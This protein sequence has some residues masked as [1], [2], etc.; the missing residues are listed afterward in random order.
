MN[1]TKKQIF[2]KSC[3]KKI[4]LSPYRN[5]IENNPI[6]CDKCISQIKVKLEIKKI[7]N[8][9]ILFISE[10]DGLLKSMLMNY[11]EYGDIELAPCFLS[12]F[13][14]V[15]KTF[16]LGYTFIPCP[17]SKARI[18]KR[19]FDHLSTILKSSNLKYENLLIKNSIEEQKNSVGLSRFLDKGI[20]LVENKERDIDKFILFDDVFTTGST[21]EQSLVQLKKL[22]PKRIKGMIIMDNYNPQKIKL[23]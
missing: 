17:S 15:I 1:T 21:F 8:I 5:F 23:H 13:L 18:E 3:F 2:C 12:L 9:P 19:G 6:L 11:K 16:S 20:S 4:K 14:P 22:N 7:F 10:Y